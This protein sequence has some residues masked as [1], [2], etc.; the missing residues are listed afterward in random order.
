MK[1]YNTCRYQSILSFTM[2]KYT[3]IYYKRLTFIRTDAH[4]DCA[5]H[6]S[7]LREM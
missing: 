3:Q 6:Y 1:E 4:R 5:W 7:Q 2:L